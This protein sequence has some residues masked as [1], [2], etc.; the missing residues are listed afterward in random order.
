[1]MTRSSE[2]FQAMKVASGKARAQAERTLAKGVNVSQNARERAQRT[3]A[4]LN[5]KDAARAHA[6]R[7]IGALRLSEATQGK[8][9][10]TLARAILKAESL[11]N[12]RCRIIVTGLRNTLMWADMITDVVV[13]ASL[14]GTP[15]FDFGL[16]LLFMPFV[17]LAVLLFRPA[18][19][20][21]V[22]HTHASRR[23]RLSDEGM[24][25]SCGWRG[26]KHWACIFSRS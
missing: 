23:R 13:V 26:H 6:E 10:R 15:Y 25:F 21:Q 12:R 5:V 1:M 14:H 16:F 18:Y 22:G 9:E 2:T 17:V 3:L 20:L 7:A 19:R 4:N 11:D 24:R 8:A